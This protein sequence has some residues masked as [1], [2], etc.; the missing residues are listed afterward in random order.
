[1]LPPPHTNWGLSPFVFIGGSTPEH[2]FQPGYPFGAFY[3]D[4]GFPGFV[5]HP[6]SKRVISAKIA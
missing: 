5:R 4:T 2:W 6:Y 1:M 3:L